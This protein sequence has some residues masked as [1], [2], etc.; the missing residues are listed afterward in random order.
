[1]GVNLAPKCRGL[2]YVPTADMCIAYVRVMSVSVRNTD[3]HIGVNLAPKCR[4]LLYVLTADMC[5]ARVG[6]RSAGVDVSIAGGILMFIWGQ[7]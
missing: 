2:L 6:V 3:V 4:Q 5:I 1:M 7:T